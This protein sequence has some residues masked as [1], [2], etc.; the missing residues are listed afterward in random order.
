MDMSEQANKTPLLELL[1]DIPKGAH[2]QWE[3]GEFHHAMSPVGLYCHEAADRIK[4]LEVD[5]KR[6]VGHGW[7]LTERIA[8]LKAERDRLLKHTGL[9]RAHW[10][11]PVDKRSDNIDCP[12]CLINRI[13]ELQA[14]MTNSEVVV[15]LKRENDELQATIQRV[16]DLRKKTYIC[17]FPDIRKT[18]AA[19]RWRDL[20]KA[21]ENNK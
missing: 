13:A 16:R 20:Q 4:A 2:L 21:L 18:G 6:E 17:D 1:R 10:E 14:S 15:R 3:V 8:E 9:C 7:D 5:V 12:I 11:T 19:V